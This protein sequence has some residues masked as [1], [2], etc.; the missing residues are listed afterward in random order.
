MKLSKASPHE[1]Q[2]ST[3]NRFEGV[4]VNG[5]KVTYFDYGSNNSFSAEGWTMLDVAGGGKKAVDKLFD[6]LDDMNINTARATELDLEELYLNRTA[7]GMMIKTPDKWVEYQ[8][9]DGIAN[10]ADRLAKKHEFFKSRFKLDIKKTDAYKET[11][12][13]IHQAFEGG[14]FYQYRPDYK[15]AEIAAFDSKYVL[16]HNPNGL[17]AFPT[18]GILPRLKRMVSSGG[19]LRSLT[20]RMRLGITPGTTSAFK[21]MNVG[22]GSYVFLRIQ[23]KANQFSHTGLFWKPKVAR[24]ADAVSY[25]ND[26]F[27]EVTLENQRN[28]RAVT[29]KQIGANSR[30]R[31]NETIFKDGMSFYDDLSHIV[32]RDRSEWQEALDYFSKNGFDEWPDGRPLAEVLTYRGRPVP[33]PPG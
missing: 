27:G 31:N 21:D 7:F 30:N 8:L 9:L 13:G 18:S 28:Y 15:K 16:Y 24:R 19:Q 20:E 25:P 11:V 3:G 12:T 14:R 5:T 32:F 10:Q 26:Q 1:M 29:M 2:G 6:A 4:N 23:D 33:I 17:D 22:G